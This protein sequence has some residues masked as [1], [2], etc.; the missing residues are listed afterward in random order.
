MNSIPNDPALAGLAE[1]LPAAGAPQF[2]LDAVRQMTGIAFSQGLLE[3]FE[4]RPARDARML[5]SFPAESGPALLVSG[6]LF[7]DDDAGPLMEQTSLKELA[8]ETAVRHRA[9]GSYYQYLPERRVLLQLFP[10]DSKLPGLVRATSREWVARAFAGLLGIPAAQCDVRKVETITYKPSKRAALRYIVQQPGQQVHYFG[11]LFQDDR[12]ERMIPLFDTLRQQ[13]QH[14]G[15]PWDLPKPLFYVPAVQMLTMEGLEDPTEVRTLLERSSQDLQARRALRAL[16]G[17]IAQGLAP[18][19]RATVGELPEEPPKVV[20]KKLY[21]STA[22]P[23]GLAR[24]LPGGAGRFMGLVQR[25]EEN[26]ARLPAERLV[27]THGA[28]R[29]NHFL[30]RGDRPVLI[31]LDGLCLRGPSADAGDFLAYVDWR[32][33][34]HEA[35]RS[36]LD[37]CE[38]VFWTGLKEHPGLSRG[39]LNWYRAA[40]HL[41]WTLHALRSLSPRYQEDAEAILRVADGI[42][43]SGVPVYVGAT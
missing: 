42:L 38:D 7:R 29:H 6:K 15:V 24:L 33:C 30:L 13:F 37:E 5:W 31:D 25:L 17:Q 39:W 26:A 18:L 21:K 3:Y 1:L 27:L 23:E 40:G 32:R 11:K 19:Q 4:Y 8:K 10:F 35:F 22:A 41:K 16:F 12:G 9:Q 28:L 36:I 14:K 34:R 2:V 43:T 20:L